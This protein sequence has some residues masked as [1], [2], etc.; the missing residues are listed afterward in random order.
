VCGIGVC[1]YVNRCYSYFQM[2]GIKKKTTS[3][4]ARKESSAELKACVKSKQGQILS[5][6]SPL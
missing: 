2:R 5:L 6:A 3:V 4:V 1:I